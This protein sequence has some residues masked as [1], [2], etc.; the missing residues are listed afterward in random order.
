MSILLVFFQALARAEVQR[1]PTPPHL[2]GDFRGNKHATHGI[3]SHF[4]AMGRVGRGRWGSTHRGPHVDAGGTESRSETSSHSLEKERQDD[5]FENV[6]KNTSHMGSDDLSLW[7]D[8]WYLVRSCR[9]AGSAS[10]INLLF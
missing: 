6:E 5:K 10:G 2:Q 7:E 4:S 1:I 8:A 9:A 3:A